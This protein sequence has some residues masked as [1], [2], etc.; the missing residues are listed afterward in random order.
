MLSHGYPF[1]QSVDEHG[2]VLRPPAPYLQVRITNPHSGKSISTFALIDTGA[3]ACVFPA[4]LA[5]ALDHSVQGVGVHCEE[6]SGVSGCANVYKHTFNMEILAPDRQGVVQVFTGVL[7]DC[8]D[9]Q[10]PP[11]LGVLNCLC[12][13]K[14]TVDYLDQMTT[15]S[16]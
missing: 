14:I 12:H 11:L 2:K 5:E 6:V 13:F 4:S 3:D 8:I 16:N 15:I 9:Q 7:V 1:V 10:I